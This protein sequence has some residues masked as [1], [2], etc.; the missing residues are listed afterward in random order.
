MPS[1][2]WVAILM[3]FS[4]PC[5]VATALGVLVRFGHLSMDEAQRTDIVAV[6][7]DY[8]S[9]WGLT[10]GAVG[11]GICA[12]IIMALKLKKHQERKY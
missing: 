12:A 7:L 5:I 8:A 9:T 1:A 3:S 2:S 10:A 4:L 6:F 11:L